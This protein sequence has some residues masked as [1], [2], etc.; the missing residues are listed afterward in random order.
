VS[1][2]ELVAEFIKSARPAVV[3]PPTAILTETLVTA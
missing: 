2:V 3:D 1:D